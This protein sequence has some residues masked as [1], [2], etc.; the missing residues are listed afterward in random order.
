MRKF[1]WIL[2]L[3]TALA[4]IFVGCSD[5][6]SKEKEV[7]L[8]KP[9]LVFEGAD[10]EV[11]TFG[12]A[13]YDK[14]QSK[15]GNKYTL[16]TVD[17]DNGAG[18]SG[19]VGS[20][21]F[22]YKFPAEALEY[23]YVKVEVKMLEV[24]ATSCA[25]FTIKKSTQMDDL[26]GFG[27]KSSPEYSRNAELNLGDKVG[28]VATTADM[29]RDT[30]Q[31]DQFLVSLFSDGIHFQFNH[32]AEYWK[33]GKT[34]PTE[35]EDAETHAKL[36]GQQKFTLE[37]TK[38]TFT[39]GGTPAADVELTAD[40]FAVG[41]LKQYKDKNDGVITEVT[42]E[43]AGGIDVGTIT[44]FY[45][46]S[47]ATAVPQAVGS[48]DI[49]VDATGAAGYKAVTKLKV[50]TL[51]VAAESPTFAYELNMAA[52]KPAGSDGDALVAADVA[53]LGF[54]GLD[55]SGGNGTVVLSVEGGRRGIKLNLVNVGWDAL[56]IPTAAVGSFSE[57]DEITVTG[58]LVESGDASG[59]EVMINIGGWGPVGGNAKE[60]DGADFTRTGILNETQAGNATSAGLIQIRGNNLGGGTAVLIIYTITYKKAE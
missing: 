10:I 4:M 28:N 20:A 38:V 53:P 3:M 23:K 43:G 42:V 32:Y 22:G 13:D 56:T 16:N 33:T 27:G 9:D 15:D 19:D 29:K 58:K 6:G 36:K 18:K 17:G 50:G 40:N 34:P 57:G 2:A 11:M 30:K 7:D 12:A 21:G 35:W 55:G 39:N 54:R 5:G 59:A 26:A 60:V 8:T 37:V 51:I 46:D 25:A 24:D 1:S 49:Y 48:Y 44:V 41:N 45:G 52:I 47:Y 31:A 14:F